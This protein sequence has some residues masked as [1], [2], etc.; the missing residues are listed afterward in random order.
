MRTVLAA[1]AVLL[2]TGRL[3]IAIDDTGTQVVAA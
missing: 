1:L 2:C 3:A